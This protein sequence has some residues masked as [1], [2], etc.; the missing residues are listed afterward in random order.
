MIMS[1]NFRDETELIDSIVE[2]VWTKLR[3]KM[4]SYDEGLVGIESRVEKM[5]KI[6][7]MELKNEIQLVGI[8]GMGGIGKT[9]LARVVFKKMKSEFDISCFLENVRE[10]S[11][12][13]DGVLSLQRKL[14]S[15]LNIKG[16][17]IGN[18]DE[19]KNT[20]RNL[21]S[22]KKVLL[23][24]DDV[25]DIRQLES[26]VDRFWFGFGSRVI[27]TT[28]D[29]HVLTSH[30]I[31]EQSYYKI[32]VLNLD[33]SLQLLSQ[34]AFKRDQPHEQ[35]LELSKVV[36]QYACG[37]PLALNLLGSF[38]CGR[39]ESQW[40]EVVDMIQQVPPNEIVKKSLRISYNGLPHSYKTLFLDV[41]CLKGG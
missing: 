32:D 10:I 20:I 35:Y 15:S 11:Q 19:G 31:I 38:L 29:K 23:V 39:S 13:I 27:V 22:N 30:G 28:R 4:P 9:T 5:E 36:V 6:L 25:D 12:D 41:A 3:P 33:E 1:C 2:S 14:L 16:L 18:L 37:L 34:K 7:R 40:K 24:V 26:L 17:E 21:L 8:W